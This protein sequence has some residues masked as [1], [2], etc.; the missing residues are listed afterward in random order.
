MPASKNDG[1]VWVPRLD[2]PRDLNGFANHRAG[3]QRNTQAER[4][5]DFLE[6]ALHKMRGDG[7]IDDSHGVPGAQERGGDREQAQRRGGL[8]A[9]ERREKEDDFL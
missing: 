8:R 4:V 2:G 3:N 7:R 5:L 6:N 1:E 9:G